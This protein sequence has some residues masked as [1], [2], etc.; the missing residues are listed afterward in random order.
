MQSKTYNADTSPW[1]LTC[2]PSS[3]CQLTK[4]MTPH[5]HR[6]GAKRQRHCLFNAFADSH[7]ETPAVSRIRRAAGENSPHPRRCDPVWYQ[8]ASL[9][10]PPIAYIRLH[11]RRLNRNPLAQRRATRQFFSRGPPS[12]RCD[13]ASLDV[14]NPSEDHTAPPRVRKE[15]YVIAAHRE[16]HDRE[17]TRR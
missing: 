13:V 3:R 16:G 12:A 7:F 6:A 10:P 9:E 1:T 5:G 4:K 11:L 8:P 17:G 14:P 15:P 2:R